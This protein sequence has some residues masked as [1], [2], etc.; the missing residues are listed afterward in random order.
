MSIFLQI[1]PSESICTVFKTFLF[2]IVTIAHNRNKHK[3][4]ET[5]GSRVARLSW[6]VRRN[7]LERWLEGL[8]LLDWR[9]CGR[10]LQSPCLQSVCPAPADPQ[11][12]QLYCTESHLMKTLCQYKE[13]TIGPRFR[14]L[15]K[16][17]LDAVRLKWETVHKIQEFNLWCGHLGWF[18]LFFF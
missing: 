16:H 17:W 3:K 14:T 10:Q 2:F 11:A 8:V 1:I 6:L 7:R 12:V 18:I 5:R 9:S 4:G 13:N 15:E